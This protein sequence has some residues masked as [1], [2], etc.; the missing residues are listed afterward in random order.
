MSV[1]RMDTYATLYARFKSEIDSRL[2]EVVAQEKPVSIFEPARYILGSGGKR[3]RPVLLLSSCL[4]A[5]GDVENAYDAATAVEIL[6]NFTLVHD[7]IMDNAPAR[8]GQ[9]TVHEQWD[10][11]I[12]ILLGDELMGLA[13]RQLLRTTSNRLTDILKCFTEGVIEVCEGQ[14]LDKEFESAGAVSMDQYWEMIQ[15]KTGRL[16]VMSADIGAMIAEA[17]DEH[18]R[19]IIEYATHI[20]LAFQV[21]DDLLD[22]VADDSFGKV[23]G[24]DIQE[25]KKTFLLVDAME[26]ARGEALEWLRNVGL[27]RVTGD[28]VVKKTTALF[29]ELGSIDRARGQVAVRTEKS[30]AALRSL[31]D[32]EG[33]GMLEWFARMLLHRSI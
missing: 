1:D 7:D 22:T 18:H 6:H 11:N 12:A 23:I 20:G 2:S 5:G 24:R 31:P 30:L 4:A 29:H 32:G 15:K 8:R 19:G 25:G 27:R 14:A 3:I 16:M 17:R 13:Y 26:H 33:K 10:A 28:D 21:L 9:K